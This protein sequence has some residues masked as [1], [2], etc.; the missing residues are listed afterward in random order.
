MIKHFV[1]KWGVLDMVSLSD[2]KY[3][4]IILTFEDIL[5]KA[6][7]FKIKILNGKI[8]LEL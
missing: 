3:I 5:E 7:S 1:K 4:F 6:F 2:H 8:Y